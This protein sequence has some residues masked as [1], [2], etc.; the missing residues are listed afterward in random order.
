M[1]NKPGI[2]KNTLNVVLQKLLNHIVVQNKYEFFIGDIS[3][4]YLKE[5]PYSYL[6]VMREK[7]LDRI[8]INLNKAIDSVLN[9]EQFSITYKIDLLSGNKFIEK[10][11]TEMEF[12]K[13]EGQEIVY[14]F[15]KNNSYIYRKN[16][17]CEKLSCH[18]INMDIYN[19]FDELINLDLISI[20]ELEKVYSKKRS[21]LSYVAENYNKNTLEMMKLRLDGK[22]LE[23]VGNVTGVTRERVRQ[24]VKKVTSSTNQTFKEDENAYWFCNYDIDK[25]QYQWMF[26]DNLYYYLSNRYEKGS[27]SWENILNDDKASKQLKMMVRNKLLKGKIE[28]GNKIISK[29]RISIIDYVLEEFGK[30]VLHIDDISEIINLFLDELGLDKEEFEIDIRYLE[31][32][33]SDT[34]NAVSRGKKYYR[35]Y[36][37]DVYDWDLFYEEI[38]FDEWK[39]LEI[40]TEILFKYHPLLMENYNIKHENELHNI[41]RRT[42]ENRRY[43]NIELSRMPNISIGNVDR[44]QQ[45]KDL[46]YEHAPLY[47]D[48]FVNLYYETFGVK[49]QTVKANYL[50]Y[51]DKY[52]VDDYIKSNFESVNE[53]DLK[54]I[55]SIIDGRKFMF[56]EDLKELLEHDMSDLQ[57]ILKHINYKT[58]TSYILKSEYETSVNYYNEKFYNNMDIVDLSNIDKRIWNLSSF[59]AWLNNKFKTMELLEFSPKKYITSKKLNEIGLTRDILEDFRHDVLEKLSDK[60]VWTINTII[61]V[62]DNEKIDSFGFE[63][64]FYRSIL[65]G[66]ENIYSNKIGGNYLLKKDQDFSFS[67][68]V[69]E[70]VTKVKMIDIFDLTEIIN[71]KYDINFVYYKL[72]ESIKRTTMYYD[73]IMEKVYLDLNYYY[74][75]F[76]Y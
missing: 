29:T 46:M 38:N 58:F 27:K 69:E 6:L 64:I 1:L 68:L 51:I 32:R 15:V 39:N 36:D 5:S 44:E 10:I 9:S 20:D 8:L 49:E 47:V 45:V 18:F 30:D 22:T 21:I 61:D 48:E 17:I 70:E 52:I 26:K 41:I 56:I 65:R 72:I 25:K 54:Y 24:V 7:F 13:I 16:E 63:P 37:Y 4:L 19:H 40:S 73:E 35:Y 33:L 55:E 60:K 34:S 31:N 3:R 23:E 59:G 53:D 67:E 71:E 11:I 2:S 57:I 76:E 42:S 12:N 43:L 74:E 75:E 50:K 28:I 14:S 66:M 62:I